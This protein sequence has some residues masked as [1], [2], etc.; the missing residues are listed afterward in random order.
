MKENIILQIN[1]R[2]VS[3]FKLLSSISGEGGVSS[4]IG[5]KKFS[6]FYSATNVQ[7]D[8]KLHTIVYVNDVIVRIIVCKI[9]L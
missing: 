5:P 6:P 1:S 3:P 9:Q 4:V 7:Q 8:L 2:E